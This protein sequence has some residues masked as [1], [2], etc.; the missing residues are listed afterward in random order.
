[1][2]A[3]LKDHSFNEDIKGIRSLPLIVAGGIWLA[4][5]H[6]FFEDSF[7]FPTKCDWQSIGIISYFPLDNVKIKIRQITVEEI[8]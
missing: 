8:D 2:E 7:M 4:K 5:N 6:I 1:M 3:C